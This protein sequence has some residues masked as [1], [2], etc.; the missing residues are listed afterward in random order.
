VGTI[1]VWQ[2]VWDVAGPPWQAVRNARPQAPPA[3]PVAT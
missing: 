2:P 1:T 3:P